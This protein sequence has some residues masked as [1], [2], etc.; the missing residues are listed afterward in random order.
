MLAGNATPD[1]YLAGKECIPNTLRSSALR[2]GGTRAA[3]AGRTSRAGL[4]VHP[5]EP[6]AST[7]AVLGVGL[8]LGTRH[9]PRSKPNQINCP[10]MEGSS[11]LLHGTRFVLQA[12][13]LLRDFLHRQVAQALYPVQ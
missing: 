4:L 12:P 13:P 9:S 1:I 11:Y 6:R 10:R 8:R 5:A 3:T 7:P 2:A